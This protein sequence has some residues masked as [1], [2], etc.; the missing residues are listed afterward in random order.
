MLIMQSS[1]YFRLFAL[2]FALVVGVGAS[3]NT[4]AQR[5]QGTYLISTDDA[6]M[7]IA[8]DQT[9]RLTFFNPTTETVAGPQV[10]VFDGADNL[11]L[12]YNHT[13]IGS[14]RFDSFDI[15]YSA[16][17]QMFG[18]I[19]SGRRQVRVTTSIVFTGLESD[20]KL[21]RPTWELMN[22]TS[23]ESILI[24]MLLPAVQKVR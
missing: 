20:A 21:F 10:R 13:P 14:R 6:I 22:T 18:E 1:R 24:G 16:L 5:S 15:P 19:G 8:P 23:G 3:T 4:L 7:G 9:L 2:A 17:G 11:L 12:S